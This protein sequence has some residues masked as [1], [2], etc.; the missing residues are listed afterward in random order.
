MNQTTTRSFGNLV[1]SFDLELGWGSVENGLWRF[2]ERQ[3]V[4]RKLRPALKRLLAA[5]DECEVAAT[6]GTVGCLLARPEQRD[7]AHL[8]EALRGKATCFLE[9]AEESSFDG[10]DLVEMIHASGAQHEFCSHTYSHTRLGYPG[11]NSEIVGQE[12]KK[13]A[14]VFPSDLAWSN[15]LIFPLNQEGYYE[16]IYQAGFRLVRGKDV[17]A[18]TRSLVSKSFEL[19]QTPLPSSRSEVFP[20]LWRETDSMLFNT[21]RRRWKLPF[22]RRRARLGLESARRNGSTFHVWTHPF[23]LAA[24]PET[25]TALIH[26]IRRAAKMR[27]NDGDLEIRTMTPLALAEI[28]S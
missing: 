7:V 9:D 25:L 23:D 15:S 16:Q 4:F 28:G 17:D 11:L 18:Q 19:I 5:M 26:L 10:R 1:I 20:G 14:D 8:P 22:V 24:E 27:D 21:G 6:W 3:G 12:L 2:L 13:F